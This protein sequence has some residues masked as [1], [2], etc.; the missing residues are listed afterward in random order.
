[1]KTVKTK[2]DLIKR[3]MLF[4]LGIVFLPSNVMANGSEIGLPDLPDT[5]CLLDQN[6]DFSK[7]QFRRIYISQGTAEHGKVKK[8]GLTRILDLRA[9]ASF[10]PGASGQISLIQVNS[11]G[12]V[13]DFKIVGVTVLADC[14]YQRIV[15]EYRIPGTFR[16]GRLF[17]KPLKVKEVTTTSGMV[18]DVTKIRYQ[19]QIWESDG[20]KAKIVLYGTNQSIMS[21]KSAMIPVELDK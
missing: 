12:V 11:L 16:F 4:L 6:P 9:M 19:Y 10:K 8:Q 2:R 5:K 15:L 3:V 13:S 1:M 18:K 17:I 20:M 7:I 14:Q 21:S